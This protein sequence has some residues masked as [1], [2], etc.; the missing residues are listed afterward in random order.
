MTQEEKEDLITKSKPYGNAL[1]Y[2]PPK[3]SG[4]IAINQIPSEECKKY[5]ENSRIQVIR[6]PDYLVNLV[7]SKDE[8]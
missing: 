3:Y 8:S 1:V 7:V 4:P 5:H 2:R 6:N